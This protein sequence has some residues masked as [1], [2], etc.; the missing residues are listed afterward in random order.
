[1]KELIF[2]HINVL[3]IIIMALIS[4]MISATIVN[5][6]N[7]ADKTG[8]GYICNHVPNSGTIGKTNC[9]SLTNPYCTICDNTTP[10]SNCQPR[11]I[12]KE[13]S[14]E[15]GIDPSTSGTYT[16]DKGNSG[17]SKGIDTSDAQEGGTLDENN[18]NAGNQ[19]GFD[20]NNSG[21]FIFSHSSGI[22]LH[23]T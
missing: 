13:D 17:N 16:E 7:A 2:P 12:G 9:C 21:G 1:M 3:T 19:K 5:S 11:T 23:C 14:G 4:T 15:K 8:P 22:I 20:P 6:V 10:P 18:E